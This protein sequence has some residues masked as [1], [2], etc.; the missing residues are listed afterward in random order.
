MPEVEQ[1]GVRHHERGFEDPEEPL[2]AK[3]GR[4]GV[5]IGIGRD[6]YTSRAEIF[7]RSV[8][9]ADADECG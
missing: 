9:R 6:V 5:G 1:I 4:E 7:H 8:D 2:V 3:N